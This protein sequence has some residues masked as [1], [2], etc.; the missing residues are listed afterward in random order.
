MRLLQ[1]LRRQ[2]P[3]FLMATAILVLHIFVALTGPLWAPYQP[4]AMLVGETF[5]PPAIGYWFG[6]DNLGRD[7]FSRV[8]HG[9]RIVL[10][11][12]V[13]AAGLAVIF[14]AAVG[15]ILAYKRGRV[16]MI[17]MRVVDLIMSI[18]PLILTLLVLTAVDSSTPVIVLTIT[19]FFTWRVAQTVRA[20]ALSVVTED[21]V[22]KARLRGESAWSV[23]VREVL[24][25]VASTVFVEFSLRTGSVD[26]NFRF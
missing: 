10:F 20:A 11:P 19:F 22:T 16:D 8:M 25:N 7:V 23:A 21:F 2:T 14:G 5:S 13:T 1:V 9:E 15:T 4:E 26:P 6:T 17:G 18:P 12:A 3:T 24:P